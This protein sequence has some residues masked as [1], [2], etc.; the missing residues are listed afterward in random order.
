M[1]VDLSPVFIFEAFSKDCLASEK[2]II[3]VFRRYLDCNRPS[4]LK[5]PQD[6]KLDLE[7]LNTDFCL[8]A[9]LCSK[10]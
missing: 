7:F 3:D 10:I 8:A 9:H 4:L 2:K 1:I 5:F 6:A